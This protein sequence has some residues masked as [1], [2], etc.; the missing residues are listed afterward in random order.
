[1]GYAIS[2][3]AVKGKSPE[4]LKKELGLSPT[5]EMTEFGDSLYTGRLLPNGWF[6]LVINKCDHKF[7][8][9][10]SLALLSSDCEV[11]ASSIEEHVMFSSSEMWKSGIQVW[12]IEHDA[13]K[14]IEHVAAS[15]NLPAEYSTIKHEHAEEQKQSG[16]KDADVDCY[17]E[18]PLHIA[19]NIVGF[20]HDE[21]DLEDESFEIFQVISSKTHGNSADEHGKAPWWKFW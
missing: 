8:K 11:I 13:Q 9:A 21:S 10:N 7:I 20:K 14:S 15:G 5:G 1:M 2:W 16:G 18:I 6:L 3:L 17:F 12:R 4:V 19:N